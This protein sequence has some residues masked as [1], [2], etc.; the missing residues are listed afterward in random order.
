MI[1]ARLL[2]LPPDLQ[3][4]ADINRLENSLNICIISYFD[5]LAPNRSITIHPNHEPWISLQIKNL[6]KERDKAYIFA[7]QSDSPDLHRHFTA[8][9]SQV[10]NSLDTAK[11]DYLNTFLTN[12][13]NLSKQWQNLRSMGTVKKKP[14]PAYSF[15]L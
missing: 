8:L 11:N 1:F 14:P 2:P 3:Y 9:R 10:L 13:P 6:M 5:Q 7:S 15:S 12:S 4:N